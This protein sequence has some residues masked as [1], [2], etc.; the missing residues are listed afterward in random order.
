MSVRHVLW[1]ALICIAGSSLVAAPTHAAGQWVL[2]NRALR[3]SVDEESGSWNVLDKRCN[4]LWRQAVPPVTSQMLVPIRQLKAAPTLDGQLGEW[5]TGELSL[6]SDMLTNPTVTSGNDDSSAKVYLAWDKSGFWLAANVRDDKLQGPTPEAALWHVDGIELWLGKDHWGFIPD[7]DKVR[8]ACWSNAKKETGC[9]GAFRKTPSG[10]AIEA[11]VPWSQIVDVRTAKPGSEFLLAFGLNDADKPPKRDCQLFY[12]RGYRHKDF[13][14]HAIAKLSAS[15]SP[16]PAAPRTQK[17]KGPD[18]QEIVPLAAPRNGLL[19]KLNYPDKN[20]PL[21]LAYSVSLT[22]D[23]ADVAFELGGDPSLQFD[24]IALPLPF[25][26]DN[27]KGVLVIPHKAGLLF[28]VDELAWNGKT[29]GGV[30]SMPW[31]GSADLASGQGYISI[32]ETP[33]DAMFRGAKVAGDDRQVLAVQP[34]FRPQKGQ[35]GYPRRLLYHFADQGGYVALAK[36]YRAYVRKNGR[37]KTL[38]EKRRERPNIDRLVGAVNIYSS[39][40]ENMEELHRLG[41]GRALVSGFGTKQVKQM[42]EWGW[43]TGH[44]DIYT[45]LYEPGTRPSTWERCRGFHFP[46]DVIKNAKGG[47]EIGWCPITDPKTGK[48][49]PSYVICWTC[50]LRV[51]KERVP[52][53]LA[54]KPLSAYF[55]DCVTSTGLRECYDPNH[56]LTR[57]GD[58]ETRIKQF[59]YLSGDLGLVVGSETGRDWAVPV[60][61]YFEGI[62][63]TAAF[64]ATPKAIHE[65]PFVSIP[66][67]PKYE[68]Y[69][70]NPWRRVPLFQ[71]VYSDCAE[72]TWRWGDNSHR[73]PSIWAMKDLQQI[74]HASMPTFVLWDAQQGLFLPNTDRFME[75]YNNVCRWRRAVGYYEMTNH[76]RLSDDAMVQRS[77]FANGAAVTVN[78]AKDARTV[79]GTT[80]P[81]RSYLIAGKAKELAGLPVGKPVQVSDS[82]TP[83]ELVVTGNTGFETRPIFWNR[84][85]GMKLEVQNA[86]AHSGKHAAKITGTSTG[87]WSYARGPRVDLQAGRKYRIHGW[88]RVDAV[89]PSPKAPKLKCEIRGDGKYIRN[90]FTNAYDV[91]KPGTWQELSATFTAP[92][93]AEQGQLA[94][95]KGGTDALTATLYLDDVELV[96]LDDK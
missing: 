67:D 63:S 40:F 83:K 58:R 62:M 16:E 91:S 53:V 82:W 96:P 29:L 38:A 70:I 65:I 31:F 42:N 23:E 73:M 39:H 20:G 76:E 72:I 52:K 84:V 95:E 81:P 48:K 93:N 8:I 77:T 18:V 66:S 36:R 24:R 49:D 4:R 44:Y 3:V 6:T 88:L 5:Q 64:F 13:A 54:Q 10:W 26:L 21:P 41:V 35:L 14:T 71:L 90:A 79:D 46:A 7:G 74:I 27:P 59:A 57:T 69:A 28:G 51:L 45:D 12:P 32:M 85:G 50:G 30:M 33:D 80:L 19:V 11:F 78:F 68:E 47:N 37:L 56:P 89:A 86:V 34:Q 9:R 55:L 94:L 22:G 75:C 1:L 60:A 25:V 61:D 17:P 2:E 87:G 15:T 92:A 43:L